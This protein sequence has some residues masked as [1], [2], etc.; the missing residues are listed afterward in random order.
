[1]QGRN[2]YEDELARRRA[3]RQRQSATQTGSLAQAE[4]DTPVDPAADDEAPPRFDWK[5]IFAMV[6]AAYQI[7]FPI[8]GI[9]VGAMVVAYLI[10]K[11]VFS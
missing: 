2:S 10:F 7:L 11:Y 3:A 9:M 8:L 5:D 6:I 4:T 1:M